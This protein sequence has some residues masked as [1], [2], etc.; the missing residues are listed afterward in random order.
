RHW[1]EW[2][3]RKRTHVFVGPSN[4]GVAR[5]V[6]PGDVDSP[7]YA[8]G[9]I[10]SCDYAFSPDSSEIAFEM[11]PDKIEAIST[12]IDIFTVPLNGG[13]PRNITVANRSSHVSPV[14]TPDG[15]YIIYRSQPT[16]G[17]EADR[18]RIM[19]YDRA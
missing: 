6:T 10:S 19:R 15:K 7:P 4:G 11:N 16:A 3:D 1:V 14:Y 2:R 8:A 12:N 5:D 18:F 9:F 17:F 13:T